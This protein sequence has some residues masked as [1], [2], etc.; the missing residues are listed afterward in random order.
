MLTYG[1]IV[2]S[3]ARRSRSVFN[4]DF[5]CRLLKT[6]RQTDNQPMAKVIKASECACVSI[7]YAFL[8]SYFNF[9]A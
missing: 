8:K 5:Q 4:D 1:M 9:I 7:F 2:F 3:N 6:D